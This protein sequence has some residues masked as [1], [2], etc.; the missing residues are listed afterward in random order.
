MLLRARA[1]SVARMTLTRGHGRETPEPGTRNAPPARDPAAV[2]ACRPE[3]ILALQRSAGNAA[4]VSMLGAAG[5]AQRTSR[6]RP[7]L[8][9]TRVLQREGTNDPTQ[10]QPR[11][12]MAD[13]PTGQVD[14]V[15]AL[16]ERLEQL[17]VQLR[18][19]GH[20]ARD[21]VAIEASGD[22]PSTPDEIRRGVGQLARR[23]GPGRAQEL[24]DEI[25][26]T[27]NEIRTVG[28][29]LLDG[30]RRELAASSDVG[31]DHV[32]QHGLPSPRTGQGGRINPVR[33]R[34]S[35]KQIVA[36]VGDTTAEEL[37]LQIL[38]T[39]DAITRVR[40][41]RDRAPE[42]QDPNPVGSGKARK[43]E[44]QRREWEQR[45][46]RQWRVPRGS[47]DAD[48]TAVEPNPDGTLPDPRTGRGRASQTRPDGG[49]RDR[50]PPTPSRVGGRGTSKPRGSSL[51][52]GKS[53]A[54]G[55]RRGG[56]GG[57]VESATPES[58]AG[59]KVAPEQPLVA[60][61]REGPRVAE[62]GSAPNVA[63]EPEAGGV[64]SQGESMARAAEGKAATT[65]AVEGGAMAVEQMG[66]ETLEHAEDEKAQE[67][68][69]RYEPTV[70]RLTAAGNWVVVKSW[71]DAPRAPNIT[72]GV[73]KERSDVGEFLC[74]TIQSGA[75]RDE[76]RRETSSQLKQ[77]DYG[78]GEAP[79]PNATPKDRK[80]VA[81]EV[82]EF[83]PDPPGEPLISADADFIGIYRPAK[84]DQEAGA[85]TP[86]RREGWHRELKLRAGSSSDPSS[87]V[88]MWTL[89]DKGERT[90]WRTVWVSGNDPVKGISA[91]FIQR[92]PDGTAR[93]SIQS[94]IHYMYTPGGYR[95]FEHAQGK[96]GEGTTPE[97]WSA[98]F[99]W[100]QS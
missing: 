98:V 34:R 67:D 59:G 97:S 47:S 9:A 11:G 29:Q 21:L 68:F 88:Q 49:S 86:L 37:L 19:A 33:L 5:P 54:T 81:R 38:R 90:E 57:P 36:E 85:V 2:H 41:E 32:E 27:S 65:R 78:I 42:A 93:Y 18:E 92:A 73:Y 48:L 16:E 39:E 3:A 89:D 69:K 66:I 99:T 25:V 79:P 58:P 14:D 77:A 75:T 71:F 56:S 91:L 55:Q 31:A 95:V 7:P 50:K 4:V 96:S 28:R 17:G 20:E 24:L 53:Q 10:G 26:R 82:R 52:A 70:R 45:T 8:R 12:A 74:T 6:S 63:A 35:L 62:P 22:V 94:E 76:A 100:T 40:V 84:L 1:P 15:P 13:A 83:E 72:A 23:Q 30:L 60:S 64:E 44:R 51:R 43:R 61:G 87:V 80:A 46:G